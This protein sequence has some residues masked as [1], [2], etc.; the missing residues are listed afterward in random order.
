MAKVENIAQRGVIFSD[1]LSACGTCQ[2]KKSTQ[3]KHR[4]TSRA[5]LSSER[6]KLVSTDLPGPVTPKAIGGYAYIE[7][8]TDHHSRVK[9]ASFIEEP[10]SVL[11][12][13]DSATSQARACQ[14]ALQ[15]QDSPK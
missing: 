2:L 13:A 8:Y 6:I 10:P 12:T 11:P 14:L 5:N 3:Q 4:G 7:K 15:C 1:T 9:A